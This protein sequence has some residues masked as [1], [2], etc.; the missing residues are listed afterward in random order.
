VN[1]VAV[2]PDGTT[3]VSGGG[4]GTVRV[5]NLVIRAQIGRWDG[6]SP[7][8]G[9][10]ALPGPPLR[11]GVGPRQGPPYLLELRGAPDPAGSDTPT[12]VQPEPR[13][14]EG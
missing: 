5:W 11:I 3:A 8:A 14:A 7:V 12:S 10:T 1:S 6:D 4:D 2:T 9:C 13:P